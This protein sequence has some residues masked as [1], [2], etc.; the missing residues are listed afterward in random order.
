MD[1]IDRLKQKGQD[2]IESRG[3]A[4]IGAFL[5]AAARARTFYR[6]EEETF[7]DSA[8]FL[9]QARKNYVITLVTILEMYLRDL[10]HLGLTLMIG[11][12]ERLTMLFPQVAEAVLY[13][14]LISDPDSDWSP[15][16]EFWYYVVDGVT[17]YKHPLSFLPEDVDTDYW[18]VWLKDVK[19]MPPA[20]NGAGKR[21]AS[22][23]S[24][25]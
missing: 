5:W 3:E 8:T 15:Q 16:S 7:K 4:T 21:K 1:R 19:N 2:Y 22:A 24:K 11:G 10:T 13:K 25:R 17:W 14:H 20:K 9:E 12:Y 6:A 23:K 18:N